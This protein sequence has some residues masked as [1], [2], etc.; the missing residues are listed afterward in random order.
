MRWLIENTSFLQRTDC[1]ICSFP[2]HKTSFF[3]SSPLPLAEGPW[4]MSPRGLNEG[5]PHSSSRGSPVMPP[6]TQ[7]GHQV[8]TLLPVKKRSPGK[9]TVLGPGSTLLAARGMLGKSWH[10]RGGGAGALE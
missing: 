9:T 4:G 10:H 8:H 3:N 7:P 6:Q 5:G 1:R 2:P